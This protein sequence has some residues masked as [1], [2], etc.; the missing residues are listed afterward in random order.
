MVTKVG[1]W[2]NGH[3]AHRVR[4]AQQTFC[5]SDLMATCVSMNDTLSLRST[6][7]LIGGHRIAKAY[8]GLKKKQL[9]FTCK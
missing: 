5:D 8:H 9:N 7:F 4:K 2:P 3:N 6:S 1:Y